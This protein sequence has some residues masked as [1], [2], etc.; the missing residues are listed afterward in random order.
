M[1]LPHFFADGNH[2]LFL[3]VIISSAYYLRVVDLTHASHGLLQGLFLML[4]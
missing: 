2:G 4:Y 3:D 1:H